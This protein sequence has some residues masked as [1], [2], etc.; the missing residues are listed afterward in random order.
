MSPPKV[1]LLLDAEV[2]AR[3]EAEVLRPAGYALLPRPCPRPQG[4]DL[5][6]IADASQ[7][8]AAREVEAL[9]PAAVIAYL[10]S[11]EQRTAWQ[12]AV[13][14]GAVAVLS[15]DWTPAQARQALQAAA[16]WQQ[17]WQRWCPRCAGLAWLPLLERL[18]VGV[19]LTSAQETWVWANPVAWAWIRG[20]GEGDPQALLQIPEV[21]ALVQRARHTGHAQGSLPSAQGKTLVGT[22]VA[23]P[24]QGTMVLIQDLSALQ[25]AEAQRLEVIQHLSFQLRSPLTAILGYAELLERAGALNDTQRS[26]LQRIYQGVETLTGM[27]EKLLEIGRVEAGVDMAWEVTPLAPLLRYTEQALRPQAE[28]KGLTL[29]A[30]V[31]ADLPAVKAPPARVRQVFDHLVADAIRYTPPGGRV[32]LAAEVADDQV[33]VRVQDTGLGIPADEIP[34]IFE[35]FYRA[36]NVATRFAGN[37]LGLT[38]VRSIVTQLGGRIWVDSRL[39]EGTTFAVLLPVAQGPQGEAEGGASSA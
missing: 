34:K 1:C 27:L 25:Q 19:I 11:P 9:F 10:P 37:G 14:W 15:A 29:E 30:R 13:A 17:R 21:Q 6:V 16:A 12:Q 31:P 35:R 5:V 26:F 23:H 33:I 18:P 8:E 28:A 20:Q 32:T 36:T 22:A 24:A 38:L 2:A 7:P 39:G 4:L 3:L